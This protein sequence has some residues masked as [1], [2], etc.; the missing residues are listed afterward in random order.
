MIFNII[1]N[2]LDKI[3]ETELLP[4][5]NI[6]NNCSL[7]DCPFFD[8]TQENKNNMI[9]LKEL[10]KK[11]KKLKSD[12]EEIKSKH[13][14]YSKSLG[15]LY[16]FLRVLKNNGLDVSEMMDNISSGEDYD[17]Y[18]EDDIEE[19][20]EES[21]D[22][23]KEIVLTDGSVLTNVNQLS[24]GMIKEHDEFL[25]SKLI[26]KSKNVPLLNLRKLKKN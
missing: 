6:E 20:E 1:S 23:K 19:S 12:Y 14:E 25:K 22:Q 16:K 17:E 2:N 24:S 15:K 18:V 9:Y 8:F 21:E 11:N 13:I 7:K 10:E 26:S 4:I 5:F 3:Y